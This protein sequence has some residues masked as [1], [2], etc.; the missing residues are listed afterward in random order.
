MTS[1]VLPT[2]NK[3]LSHSRMSNFSLGEDISNVIIFLGI[4]VSH[5]LKNK[6]PDME[7]QRSPLSRIGS[8]AGHSNVAPFGIYDQRVTPSEYHFSQF[9]YFIFAK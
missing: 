8:K 4:I 2:E 3:L 9:I 1:A 6:L 7:H 5:A